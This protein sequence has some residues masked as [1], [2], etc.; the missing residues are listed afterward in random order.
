MSSLSGLSEDLPT[1]SK[2]YPDQSMAQLVQENR[3]D[4]ELGGVRTSYSELN[5]ISS[6]HLSAYD[7]VEDS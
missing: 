1:A 6:A 7:E 4:K 2:R 3:F 5:S